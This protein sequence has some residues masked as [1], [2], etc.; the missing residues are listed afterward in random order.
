MSEKRVLVHKESEQT[1]TITGLETILGTL[2][3]EDCLLIMDPSEIYQSC[4]GENCWRAQ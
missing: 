2:P 3:L 1:W 4:L